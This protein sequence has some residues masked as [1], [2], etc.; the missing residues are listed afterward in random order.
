MPCGK[1]VPRKG[2]PYGVGNLGANAEPRRSVG[3]AVQIDGI[4]IPACSRL[5][6]LVLRPRPWRLFNHR[7]ADFNFSRLRRNQ[8][9]VTGGGAFMSSISPLVGTDYSER[10]KRRDAVKAILVHLSAIRDAEQKCLDNVPENLQN[11][12]SFEIGECTVDI[13]DETIGLLGDAY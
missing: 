2:F 6:S 10:R 12:D 11:S 4:P 7:E 5:S 8:M 3:A 1:P 9:H 13:L